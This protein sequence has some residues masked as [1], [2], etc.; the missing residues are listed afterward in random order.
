[1]LNFQRINVNCR[2]KRISFTFYPSFSL[3]Y[4]R[5]GARVVVK[6]CD[7]GLSKQHMDVTTTIAGTILYMA[8]EVLSK[9]GCSQA[10]DIYSAGLMLWEMYHGSQAYER[11]TEQLTS[12]IE[13][14][15]AICRGQLRLDYP[16]K[17][18]PEAFKQL[19]EACVAFDASTRPPVDEVHSSLR[20][21]LAHLDS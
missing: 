16:D 14:E 8:P 15:R 3:Q 5:T 4:Q 12:I 10:S 17:S 13:V 20:S 2:K 6:L 18:L 7:F 21:F 19:I 9:H 1:M 11:S